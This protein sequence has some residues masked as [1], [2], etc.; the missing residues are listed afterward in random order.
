MSDHTREDRFT[1]RICLDDQTT[2][3]TDLDGMARPVG[4]PRD[5]PSDRDAETVVLID[6]PA[7]GVHQP[8]ELG[9]PKTSHF[10]VAVVSRVL[11]QQ[12]GH[13]FRGIG[14]PQIQTKTDHHDISAAL[15]EDPPDLWFGPAS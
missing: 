4:I 2:V 7:I 5:V 8:H 6:R 11:A 3:I 10:G 15:D 12:S 1:P 14:P 9:T 13:P